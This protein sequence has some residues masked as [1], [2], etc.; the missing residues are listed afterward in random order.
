VTFTNTNTD[1]ITPTSTGTPTKTFTPTSTATYTF[2]FTA[3]PTFTFTPTIT[4]TFTNTNVITSTPTNTGTFTFTPTF[5]N[6]NGPT[7]TFTA[8]STSTPLPVF[9]L[10][11]NASGGTVNPGQ[12]LTYTL[13]L[14]ISSSTANQVT[15]T[16][17]LPSSTTFQNFVSGPAGTLS[18]GQVV[19]NLGTLSPA[20]YT[21]S[22][23]VQ[24]SNSAADGAILSNSAVADF[25][26]ESSSTNANGF[27]VTVVHLT[28]TPTFTPTW[29]GTPTPSFTSTPGL[30]PTIC[31]AYPNPV[32][33]N[34]FVS[35]CVWVP[36]A[37]DV[38]MTVYTT[39]FRKIYDKKIQVVDSTIL[40][41]DLRDQW[42]TPI[43]NGLYYVRIRVTGPASTTK[44]SKVLVNR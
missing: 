2:T 19:W 33:N 14:V 7:A 39:A 6:T 35:M 13:T 44:F 41:W 4:A 29:T 16:D 22:F 34:D 12:T 31:P 21:F 24:V 1:V 42:G 3:T 11:Q 32:T 27:N 8:T 23:N 38:E 37:S 9:Q 15:I 18:G 43:A 36:G 25:Q 17:N 30:Q 10:T 20:T 28:S 5:T 40:T 26:G